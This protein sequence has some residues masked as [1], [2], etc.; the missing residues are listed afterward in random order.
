MFAPFVS[1]LSRKQKVAEKCRTLGSPKVVVHAG[2]LAT[3]A[4]SKALV[5]A[6]AVALGGIDLLVVSSAQQ[7]VYVGNEQKI[8]LYQ[9]LTLH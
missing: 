4:G 3:I 6:S 5:T 7:G 8:P 2:D 9:C 1:A